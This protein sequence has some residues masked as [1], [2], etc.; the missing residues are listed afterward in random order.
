MGIVL[1]SVILY[2]SINYKPY[3]IMKKVLFLTMLATLTF[4]CS[5]DDNN[6]TDQSA[7]GCL[8]CSL[9]IEGTTDSD[10]ICNEDGE[11]LDDGNTKGVDYDE[12]IQLRR[13][14]GYTCE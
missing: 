10:E 7:S 6:D 4:A 11:A 9:T 8:V 1:Q 2:F 3:T 14:A 5:D 13:D 12:Y